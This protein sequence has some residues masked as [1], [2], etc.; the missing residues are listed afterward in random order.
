MSG[1][2]VM[3]KIRSTFK[4]QTNEIWIKNSHDDKGHFWLV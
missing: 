3:I 4:P 1:E 2:Y